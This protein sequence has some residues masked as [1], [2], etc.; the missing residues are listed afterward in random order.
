MAYNAWSVSFGEQPSAA[1]WNYLGTNDAFFEDFILGTNGVHAAWTS[2]TPT[3]TNLTVGNGTVASYYTKIGRTVHYQG[4]YT[5]GTTSVQG[6]NTTVN[7]PVPASSNYG[8]FNVNQI[9]GTC[10]FLDTGV[11]AYQGWVRLDG[12]STLTFIVGGASG[13]YLS[14]SGITATIPF[15]WG[16]GDSYTWNVTYEA[17]S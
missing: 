13:T 16:S 6:A 3:F 8:S 7:L 2:F 11:A 15:S 14:Q 17:A 5:H 10:T 1:K 4:R 12:A 9:I